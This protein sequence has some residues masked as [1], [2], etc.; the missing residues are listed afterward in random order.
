MKNVYI[1]F[2]HLV[3]LYG[4][5]FEMHLPIVITNISHYSVGWWVTF[6]FLSIWIGLGPRYLNQMLKI[7]VH[8]LSLLGLISALWRWYLAAKTYRVLQEP[9]ITC[10][11]QWLRKTGSPTSIIVKA[12]FKNQADVKSRSFG[13]FER[14]NDAHEAELMWDCVKRSMSLPSVKIAVLLVTDNQYIKTRT[15]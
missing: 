8:F 10:R 12:V 5:I 3:T 13:H 7:T 6:E 1:P 14:R 2:S 15:S 11:K 9:L 4:V